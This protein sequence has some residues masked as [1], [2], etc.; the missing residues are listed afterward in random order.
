MSRLMRKVFNDFFVVF[1]IDSK[2]V[3]NIETKVTLGDR[4]SGYIDLLWKGVIAPS[5]MV[6]KLFYQQYSTPYGIRGNST[7]PGRS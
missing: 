6:G 5:F 3:G 4:R 7:R 2:R 1:G